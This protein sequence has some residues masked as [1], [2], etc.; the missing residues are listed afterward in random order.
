MQNLDIL[1]MSI[2]EKWMKSLIEKTVANQLQWRKDG[3]SIDV[4]LGGDQRFPAI[5]LVDWRERS[6]HGHFRFCTSLSSATY[7]V[8]IYGDDPLYEEVRKLFDFVRKYIDQ[9]NPEM[10]ADLAKLHNLITG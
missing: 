5:S 8:H 1:P 10:R 4:E 3:E 9:T 2:F 7:S 6:E